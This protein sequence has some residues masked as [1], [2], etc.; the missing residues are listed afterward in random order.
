MRRAGGAAGP[1]FRVDPGAGGADL[2]AERE[3]QARLAAK[4]GSGGLG[5]V[6]SS[7]AGYGGSVGL[8]VGGAGRVGFLFFLLSLLRAAVPS[9]ASARIRSGTGTGCIC[10]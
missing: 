10:N 5:G 9:C 4:F 1:G 3:A 7:A 2:R 8:P 6:G